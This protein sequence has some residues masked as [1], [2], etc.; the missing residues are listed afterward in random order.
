MI[1]TDNGW[2]I[3]YREESTSIR[4][5]FA[6][7]RTCS[8]RARRGKSNRSGTPLPALQCLF[9][10]GLRTSG[11]VQETIMPFVAARQ[12]STRP[13]IDSYRDGKRTSGGKVM[14]DQRSLLSA[15]YC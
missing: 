12:L 3:Y 9:L 15:P 1:Q 10:D 2:N 6:T 14:V 5:I 8:A 4:E 13:I 7:Y 11:P